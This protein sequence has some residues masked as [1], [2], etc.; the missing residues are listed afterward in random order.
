VGGSFF[1]V[2]VTLDPV[3]L[4]NDT[5]HIMINGTLA[6]GTLLLMD[7]N[8]FFDAH[9]APIGAGSPFDVFLSIMLSTP[10]T[11][12]Q[13]WLPTP[14]P[15]AVA[16]AGLDCDLSTCT[17]AQMAAD[18]AA[19]VHTSLAANEVDFFPGFTIN[20]ATGAPPLIDPLTG[21]PQKTPLKE[22]DVRSCTNEAHFT[23]VATVPEPV[24]APW[25]AGD[26]PGGLR[27]TRAPYQ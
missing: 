8:V 10:P 14:P 3:N 20:P 12:P 18:Q 26:G 19:N 23:V 4:A 17:A 7:L 25:R 22:C 11:P 2:F 6:G 1:D 21:L 13:G 16:V 5:G 15:F 9:F 24:D 27:D